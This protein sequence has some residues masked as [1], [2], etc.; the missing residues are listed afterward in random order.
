MPEQD[1]DLDEVL[2]QIR[3]RVETCGVLRD[4]AARLTLRMTTLLSEQAMMVRGEDWR[5][6][7]DFDGYIQEVLTAVLGGGDWY[8]RRILSEPPIHRLRRINRRAYSENQTKG[9]SAF[10]QRI[11]AEQGGEYCILCGAED[12]LQV[13]H[14]VPVSQAGDEDR[15]S[16]LQLLC[17]QCNGGKNASADYL[18][19]VLSRSSISDEATPAQRYYVLKYCSMIVHFIPCCPIVFHNSCYINDIHHVRAVFTDSLL[20]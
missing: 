8:E 11:V 19:P 13:D 5:R 17:N 20:R 14:I 6:K 9:G 12:N 18:M 10:R 4:N 2:G 3:E 16:N 1:L 15:I 7:G